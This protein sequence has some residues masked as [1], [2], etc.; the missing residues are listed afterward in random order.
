MFGARTVVIILL[1]FCFVVVQSGLINR[2]S[3]SSYYN[4]ETNKDS[5]FEQRSFISNFKRNKVVQ[6][7]VNLY[8][9]FNG[10]TT[11][12]N[13]NS[14]VSAFVTTFGSPGFSAVNLFMNTLGNSFHIYDAVGQTVQRTEERI[15]S[16]MGEEDRYF[17]HLE[18]QKFQNELTTSMNRTFQELASMNRAVLCLLHSQ[19]NDVKLRALKNQFCPPIWLK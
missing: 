14:I 19:S 11:N 8:K 17:E 3:S 6:K 16:R 13:L 10:N 4:E 7:L 18:R 12:P 9:L 1:L 15:R 2:R 5:V